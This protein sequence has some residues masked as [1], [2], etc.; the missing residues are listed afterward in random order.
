M[1]QLHIYENPLDA[2]SITIE[3]TDNVLRRFLEIKAQYPQA[4]IYK[5]IPSLKMILRLLTKYQY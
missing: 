4:R 2:S 1:S 3:T 5:N